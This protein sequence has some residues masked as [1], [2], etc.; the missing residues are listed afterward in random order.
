V[1]LGRIRF[2][3]GRRSPAYSA[4]S[5]ERDLKNQANPGLQER[6]GPRSRLALAR[7]FSKIGDDRIRTALVSLAEGI[8][9][10]GR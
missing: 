10:Q 6:T 7:A 5:P 3:A 1:V 4:C 8:A 2:P 9:T